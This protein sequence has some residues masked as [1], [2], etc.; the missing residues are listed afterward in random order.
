E[1]HEHGPGAQRGP[2][3]RLPAQRVGGPA[4]VGAAG[5]DA[6]AAVGDDGADGAGEPLPLRPPF[7]LVALRRECRADVAADAGLGVEA[8]GLGVR[9]GRL[10]GATPE[11][12]SGSP[13][14]WLPR[15][16]GMRP[17][18]GTTG[19][20]KEP[21]LGVAEKTLPCRSTTAQ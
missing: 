6:A 11:G 1:E 7:H 3:T 8:A 12:W 5:E 21:S 17:S 9:R 4:R 19:A 2:P 16:E 15:E 14:D 10:P 18:P 13:Q 20:L